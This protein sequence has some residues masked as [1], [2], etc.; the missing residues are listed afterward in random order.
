MSKVLCELDGE[1]IMC[2][3][4]DNMGY[5]EGFYVKAVEYNGKERIVVRR[6][7]IWSPRRPDEKLGF[8]NICG[9]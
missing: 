9:Q 1:R 6:G 2:K 4:L 7:A 5:Q 8:N 3:V